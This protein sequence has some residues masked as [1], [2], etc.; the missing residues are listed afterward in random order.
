MP[1]TIVNGLQTNTNAYDRCRG[2]Q[3]SLASGVLK[4]HNTAISKGLMSAKYQINRIIFLH[5]N[6]KQ[7]VG[8]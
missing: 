2:V 5:M 6:S 4:I 8:Q 7:E 3:Q 1:F